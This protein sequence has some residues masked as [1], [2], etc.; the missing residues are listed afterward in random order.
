MLLVNTIKF[1]LRLRSDNTGHTRL[2]MNDVWL[3]YSH[4]WRLRLDTHG[5]QSTTCDCCIHTGNDLDWTHTADNQQR[6]TT[7]L[8]LVT[9]QIGHTWLTMN[10]VWLVYSQ[11]WA[12][13]KTSINTAANYLQFHRLHLISELCLQTPQQLHQILSTDSR[14]ISAQSSHLSCLA[15]SALSSHHGSI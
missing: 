14:A 1:Q 12:T 15:I 13:V 8:T 4:W 7:V 3:L 10:D 2:T 9:T 5:W 11:Q 6:A